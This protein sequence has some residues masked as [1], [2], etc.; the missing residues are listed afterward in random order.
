MKRL[1]LLFIT[2]CL[3]L[4]AWPQSADSLANRAALLAARGDIA[5]LRPLYRESGTRFPPYV[6]L[7]CEMALARADAHYARMLTCID[8]LTT[9]YEKEL[10]LKGRLALTQLKAE[11]LCNLGRYAELA[12]YCREEEAYY[13]RRRVKRYLIDPIREYRRKGERLGGTSTRSRLLALADRDRA[14]ALAAAYATARDSLDTFGRLRCD[15]TLASAFHRP[16]RLLACTDSLLTL[17]ADSLD[18]TELTFCLNARARTLIE[19]GQW[20]ALADFARA[21]RQLSQPHAA[22]MRL[23]EHIGEAL[24]EKPVTRVE[25]PADTCALRITYEWPLLVKAAVNDDAPRYFTLETG[26]RYTY[27]PESDARRAGLELLPDTIHLNSS[28]G[29]IAACPA[30]ARRLQLG[31]VTIHNLLLYVVVDSS[32]VRLP[33]T[34][35]LGSN[36]LLRIGSAAFYPEKILFPPTS[37]APVAAD[38]AAQSAG[39]QW[40]PAAPNLRLSRDRTLRLHV[41]HNGRERLFS[42]DTSFPNN[43]IPRASFRDAV[44]DSAVFDLELNGRHYPTPVTWN[45]FRLPD[46]D[47][48]LGTAF[49][50]NTQT[51]ALMDL[52]AMTLRMGPALEGDGT[53]GPNCPAFDGFYFERNRVA[54]ESSTTN[55]ALRDY[56]DF[57]LL[58]GKNR[59]EELL[60]LCQAQHDTPEPVF[61]YAQAEAR[62]LYELGRYAEGQRLTAAALPAT[63]WG[64]AKPP[65]A[66][67]TLFASLSAQPAPTLTGRPGTATLRMSADGTWPVSAGDRTFFA[68]IDGNAPVSWVSHK[69]AKRLKV[70]RLV[71][72]PDGGAIGLLP[73]LRIGHFTVRNLP[74]RIA[75]KKAET[76]VPRDAESGLLLGYDVLRRFAWVAFTPSATAEFSTDS[77]PR[78]GGASLRLEDGLCAEAETPTGYASVRLDWDFSAPAV[79]QGAALTLDG[80][81]VTASPAADA[82][83]RYA[84]PLGQA[85][86]KGEGVVL[87]FRNMRLRWRAGNAAR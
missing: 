56:I 76:P 10:G 49:L 87:D 83:G 30:F 18:A 37:A 9:D 7:Y 59:P 54:L 74:C 72:T 61:P 5:A 45:D 32:E 46:Y 78:Q 50:Q 19:R 67:D 29:R 60:R 41:V 79:A 14:F 40:W 53:G 23:Y 25:R 75:A 82:P 33:F 70:R 66:W 6:R 84:L 12:R 81:A 31:D 48:L 8:S 27:L 15:L 16:D 22:P 24:R 57:Q 17:Y 20:G 69:A 80:T 64:E 65:S 71:H 68:R 4:T 47:G 21:A 13:K 77:L 44:P 3:A 2:C 34:R 85:C 38:A 35:V 55:E 43:I 73:E 36:E 51:P 52:E 1:L 42:L 39:P 11:G 63:A 86:R 26:Q 58:N 62:S 28:A